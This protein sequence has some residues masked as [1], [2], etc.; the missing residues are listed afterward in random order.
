MELWSLSLSFLVDNRR[1][2]P[3]SYNVDFYRSVRGLFR[4]LE[5]RNEFYSVTFPDRAP[6]EQAEEYTKPIVLS[7]ESTRGLYLVTQSRVC[8]IHKLKTLATTGFTVCSECLRS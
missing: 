3:A 4:H 2:T 6:R 7:T 1:A 5:R 8:A